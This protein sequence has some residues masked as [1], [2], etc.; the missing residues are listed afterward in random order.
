[1]EVSN[2]FYRVDQVE[3]LAAIAS[4]YAKVG[5]K[6]KAEQLLSQALV[7]AENIYQ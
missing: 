1:L 2:S 3:A 4:N 6:D 7:I 5:Q